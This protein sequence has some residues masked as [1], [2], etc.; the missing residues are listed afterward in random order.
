LN[1]RLLRPEGWH[2]EAI[3]LQLAGLN[4][5]RRGIDVS[6]CLAYA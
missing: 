4:G 6:M 2:S 1:L 5:A 3:G